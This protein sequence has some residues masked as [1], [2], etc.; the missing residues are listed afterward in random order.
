MTRLKDGTR[1]KSLI[2]T[3]R[4]PRQQH[5]LGLD[6]VDLEPREARGLDLDRASEFAEQTLSRLGVAFL[7]AGVAFAR[8]NRPNA[9]RSGTTEI[10][11]L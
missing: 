8:A 2:Y 7:F 3:Y 4:F 9:T 6:P 1:A 11:P 5:K 10:D